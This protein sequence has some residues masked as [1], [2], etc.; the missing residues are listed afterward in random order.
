MTEWYTREIDDEGCVAHYTGFESGN[1]ILTSNVLRLGRVEHLCDPRE[2][3]FDWID[4]ASSVE[5]GSST[6]ELAERHFTVTAAK[7]RFQRNCRILC[8]CTRVKSE[9]TFC[10]VESSAY[11]RPRM[12]AQYDD[13]GHGLCLV[14]NPDKVQ[15][16]LEKKVKHQKHLLSGAVEYRPWLSNVMGGASLPSDPGID[17]DTVDLFDLINEH[18]MIRSTL[19]KKSLDWRDEAEHRWLLYSEEDGEVSLA[20][21]QCLVGIVLGP[22]TEDV[23]LETILEYCGHFK[24]PC[25]R[26]EYW[27]PKYRLTELALTPN[28]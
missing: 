10:P 19:F 7:E 3:T 9:R 16:A 4:I 27:H 26:L 8:T 13:Q 24:R 22:N 25:Y 23:D 15:E 2:R 11:G 12:W 1:K 28:P 17:W 18:D 5:D 14:L 6:A 21:D 20:L